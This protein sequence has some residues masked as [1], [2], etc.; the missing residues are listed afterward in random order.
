MIYICAR[1]EESADR[2]EARLRLRAEE[3]GCRLASGVRDIGTS[4][5]SPKSVVAIRRADVLLTTGLNRFGRDAVT[6]GRPLAAAQGT[7]VR[8]STPHGSPAPGWDPR[9]EPFLDAIHHLMR[10]QVRSAPAERTRLGIAAAR[11]RREA[12]Q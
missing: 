2:Q 10:A 9:A 7:D 11:A 5:I 6:V 8:L 4:A 1:D 12:Q 3:H